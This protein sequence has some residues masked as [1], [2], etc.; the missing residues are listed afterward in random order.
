[1]EARKVLE[2]IRNQDSIKELED[3]C[4]EEAIYKHVVSKDGRKTKVLCNEEVSKRRYCEKGYVWICWYIQ[5]VQ[6]FL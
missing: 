6:C 5:R 4:R 1:M 2:F 3:L